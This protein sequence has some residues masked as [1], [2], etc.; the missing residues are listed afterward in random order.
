[1]NKFFF[2]ILMTRYYFLNSGEMWP[3][4]MLLSQSSLSSIFEEGGFYYSYSYWLEKAFVFV[5][6]LLFS[7]RY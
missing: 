5:A 1:M 3:G 2:A 6:F 7:I 4:K